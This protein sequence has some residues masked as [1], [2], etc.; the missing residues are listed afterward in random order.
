M[1]KK[2]KMN[3]KILCYSGE[4]SELHKIREFVHQKASKFGFSDDEAN[5]IS[6]AVDE[7]CSNLIHHAFHFDKSKKICIQVLTDDDNFTVNIYDDGSPFNPLEAIQPDMQEYFKNYQRGGL[8]IKI[9]RSVMDE[10]N[11]LPSNSS[12]QQNILS[13]KKHLQM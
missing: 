2:T 3:D 7:A 6:L 13:L 5:N 11:Y 9:M 1:N 12:N 8:G 10:I 4:Y